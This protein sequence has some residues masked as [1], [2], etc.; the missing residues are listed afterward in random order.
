MQKNLQTSEAYTFDLNDIN[1]GRE[2][3]MPFSLTFQDFGPV[4]P[5]LHKIV[6]DDVIS[7]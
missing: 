6:F 7:N 2:V 1:F 3:K 5:D 4:G